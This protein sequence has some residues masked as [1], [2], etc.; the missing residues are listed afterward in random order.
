MRRSQANAIPIGR[1]RW[2]T[3]DEQRSGIRSQRVTVESNTDRLLQLATQPPTTSTS[4]YLTITRLR[5]SRHHYTGQH[6]L[7]NFTTLIYRHLPQAN[8][9]VFGFRA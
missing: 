2:L 7:H 8:D 4:H 9:P 1:W 5:P 6:R 3:G